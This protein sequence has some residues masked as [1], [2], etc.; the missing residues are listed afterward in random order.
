MVT[1]HRAASPS[2]CAVPR[3]PSSPSTTCQLRSLTALL[4]Y[5]AT[6]CRSDINHDGELDYEEFTDIMKQATPRPP[7]HSRLPRHSLTTLCTLRGRRCAETYC[8]VGVQE[9]IAERQQ[10][11]FIEEAE[12][13]EEH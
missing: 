1:T 8:A 5:H 6:C 3:H 9:T 13:Y 2:R 10:A 11:R 12:G 7:R 4:S